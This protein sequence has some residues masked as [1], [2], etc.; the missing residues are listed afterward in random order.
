MLLASTEVNSCSPL[1]Q[2]QFLKK[3]LNS[4]L[5]P[6][7]RI[8]GNGLGLSHQPASIDESVLEGITEA[9]PSVKFHSP[10]IER[11]SSSSSMLALNKANCEEATSP[12]SSFCIHF[13]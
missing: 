9:P 3:S 10:G 8:K 2:R 4:L 11:L 5:S 12:V 1:R 7:K 13:V 6:R